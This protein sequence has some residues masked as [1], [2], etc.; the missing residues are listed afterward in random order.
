MRVGCPED[1]RTQLRNVRDRLLTCT[2]PPGRS[3]RPFLSDGRPHDE[4]LASEEGR[5]QP[6]ETE[7]HRHQPAATVFR[8][9]PFDLFPTETAGLE[10]SPW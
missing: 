5:P 3:P 7:T 8:K 4:F 1:R 6:I 2:K 9:Q 10:Q